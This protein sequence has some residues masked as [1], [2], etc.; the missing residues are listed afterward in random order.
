MNKDQQGFVAFRS[1]FKVR[2]TPNDRGLTVEWDGEMEAMSIND[3]SPNL[4]M[5]SRVW[6]W[7]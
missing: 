3:F 4:A 7:E 6:F 2:W 5:K 1:H